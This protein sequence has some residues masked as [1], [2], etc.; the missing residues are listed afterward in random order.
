MG[1]S[2]GAGAIL[3]TGMQ[4]S[5]MTRTSIRL[6]Q[7]LSFC[8]TLPFIGAVLLHIMPLYGLDS[9]LIARSYGALIISF[10]CGIHWAAF[11]FFADQCPRS[12]LLMSNVVTLLAWVPL[13][14]HAVIL[15][16][17]L[18]SACF[19]YLLASDYRLMRAG[20][21]PLWFFN[22]RCHATLIVVACLIAVMV[23]S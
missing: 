9:A 5:I 7:A 1:K 18:H 3:L 16:S 13:F 10:I 12:L 21:Y 23:L 22:L 14:F 15:S 6:A 20:I 8:G 17:C 11:L 4:D 2:V 19:I